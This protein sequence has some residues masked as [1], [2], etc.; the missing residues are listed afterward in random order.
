MVGKL[1]RTIKFTHL[2]LHAIYPPSHTVYST[3]QRNISHSFVSKSRQSYKKNRKYARK[4]FKKVKFYVLF[5][6]FFVNILTFCIFI[7]YTN[8]LWMAVTQKCST[9]HH[10][11]LSIFRINYLR[12]TSVSNTILYRNII[13]TL[14]EHNRVFTESLPSLLPN[15]NN[16]PK[17]VFQT[18]RFRLQDK[19]AIPC[20]A[21]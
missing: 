1:K 18:L 21:S 4:I 19:R 9:T 10:R 8:L 13:G 16:C 14:S 3:R 20:A 11:K 12:N 2:P 15:E 7:L 17:H 5:T 6:S